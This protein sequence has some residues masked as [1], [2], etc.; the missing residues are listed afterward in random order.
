M[1]LKKQ[2][3]KLSKFN[4]SQ[5]KVFLAFLCELD[6]GAIA[7]KKLKLNEANQYSNDQILEKLGELIGDEL[8]S[9]YL[10]D[11]LAKGLFVAKDLINTGYRNSN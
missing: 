10:E 8:T 9:S 5:I 7:E 1:E 6:L 3:V 2:R 4:I 11:Y